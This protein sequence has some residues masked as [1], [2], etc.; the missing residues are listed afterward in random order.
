MARLFDTGIFNVLTDASV[1]LPGAKLYW[2]ISGSSTE[3]DTFADNDLQVPNSNPVIADANGRFPAMY[4]NS[5]SYKYV[6]TD[7]DDVTIVTRDPYIADASIPSIAPGLTDFLSGLTP[8]A[9]ANGG[10]GAT[11]AASALLNLNGQPKTPLLTSFTG[12]SIAADKLPYGNGA[13]SFA[14]TD[15]SPFARTL[16][17]TTTAESMAA[18]T[19][20]VRVTAISLSSTAAYI[21][22]AVTVGGTLYQPIIQA[23]VATVTANDTTVVDYPTPFASWSICVG[24]GGT[25][26]GETDDNNPYVSE[27]HAPNFYVFSGAD[28]S[29]PFFWHAVGV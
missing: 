20:S 9:L 7:A 23:G 22:F 13:N 24:S 8:L 12:L 1:I 5:G 19:A 2:Y 21:K 15:L 10:T 27:C 6:L 14:L 25:G 4:L 16:L 3:T 11:S 29:V 17:A 18:I 28:A 26:D